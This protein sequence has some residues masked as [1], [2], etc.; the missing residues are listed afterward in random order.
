MNA[1]RTSLLA[2]LAAALFSVTSASAS[3]FLDGAVSSFPDNWSVSDSSAP[4]TVATKS[5][6][7]DTL[8][9]AF[10]LADD[11]TLT[12]SAS[13]DDGGTADVV[14]SNAVFTTAYELPGVEAVGGIDSQAAI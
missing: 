1:I 4:G 12:Y 9:L 5:G 8:T 10:D 11:Q 2:S 3:N 7:G 6:S 14:I 13:S